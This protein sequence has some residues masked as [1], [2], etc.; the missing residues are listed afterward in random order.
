[1]TKTSPIGEHSS[2]EDQYQHNPRN[3]HKMRLDISPSPHPRFSAQLVEEHHNQDVDEADPLI[4]RIRD[5]T[6][7]MLSQNSSD[8]PIMQT[9][10][11]SIPLKTPAYTPSATEA[12]ALTLK[13]SPATLIYTSP[14]HIVYELGVPIPYFVPEGAGVRLIHTPHWWVERSAAEVRAGPYADEVE[15]RKAAAKVKELA[16]KQGKKM[17]KT[18]KELEIEAKINGGL[19]MQARNR[20]LEEEDESDVNLEN[21][22]NLR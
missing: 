13:K 16:T 21:G 15:V 7:Y 2:D 14:S 1:M 12:L 5:G 6:V 3:P 20:S 8:L 11:F 10:R 19:R 17:T 9:T 4:V 18:L 22:F